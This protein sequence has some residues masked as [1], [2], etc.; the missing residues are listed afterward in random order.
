M[1]TDN[2]NPAPVGPKPLP[3]VGGEREKKPTK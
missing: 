1:P 2:P 3:L